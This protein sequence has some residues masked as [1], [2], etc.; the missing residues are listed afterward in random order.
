[1]PWWVLNVFVDLIKS[2]TFTQAKIFTVFSDRDYLETTK[3]NIEIETALPSR[4][5][6]IFLKFSKKRGILWSILD[7]R[8]LMFFYIPL[9]N[10]LSKKIEKY[11]PPKVVISSFAIAKNLSF[12][13]TEYSGTFN[14]IV[15]LYLHSP[16]QYIRSHYDEYIQKITWYKAKIFKYITPKLRKRDK[17]F[18]KYDDVCSNSDYTAQ[19]AKNIYGIDSKIKYPKIDQTFLN[20]SVNLSPNSYY[21]YVGRLVKFVK[22]LDKIIHLFNE[23]KQPL[24]VMW[25]GPDEEY[26]KSIT[27]WNIIFIG[28]IQDPTEKMNIMKNA[29]WLINITKES[30]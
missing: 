10:I 17:K 3:W 20:S 12:C 6:K 7:Y 2:E 27:K 13:K 11:T 22:E 25:S 24:L 19:L 23:I 28:W 16:M 26:L 29:T 9:M 1:M 5:N 30:F 15:S 4:L 14:P 18:T 21:L 8:N